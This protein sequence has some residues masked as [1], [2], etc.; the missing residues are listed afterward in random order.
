VSWEN[1]PAP[2]VPAP[3]L[4]E[5]FDAGLLIESGV[6]GVYG[7]G[8]VFEEIRERLAERLSA[9]AAHRGAQ[10]LRFPPLLPRDQ[11][12]SSGYLGSFHHLA[13]TVFAFEG[14]EREA[15][16][17]SERAAA[18]EDWS[19]F[20]RMT[21]LML[22][23][24]ACYPVYPAIAARGRLEPGGIFVDA[25]G[26]WVFRREPSFDPARRQ[27]FHQHELVRIGEPEAVLEWRDEW[28]ERGLSLLRS[29][30]LEAELERA[31]DPFFGRRGRMLAV[32]QRDQALKL[33]LLVT[34]E[35]P[36]PTAMASFNHHHD[37]FGSRFGIELSDGGTAHTACLG[38]GHERIV[39]GL[40]HAHGFDPASW[41]ADVRGQLWPA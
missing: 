8:D 16:A 5:L 35:G 36:E 34:M 29:L 40:L 12:E 3:F 41:P 13:G 24:A 32:S 9:E 33:E 17:Q 39:L 38:F 23:P 31:S 22:M 4:R 27:I 14:D 28:A 25:G 30:G 37:H 11:M 2:S 19:E 21:D 15:T 1:R 18:H 7:H 26:A 20:Q 10:R 6:A